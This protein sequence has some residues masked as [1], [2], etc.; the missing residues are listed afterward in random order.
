ML[1]RA[2]YIL[3]NDHVVDGA[4]SVRVRFEGGSSA[5]A[6]VVGTD[7]STDLA[8]LKIDPEG[9]ALTPL[10]LGSSTR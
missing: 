1:D 6:R 4:Q 5:S 10:A 8:L 9:H 3:T 7:P 2:G